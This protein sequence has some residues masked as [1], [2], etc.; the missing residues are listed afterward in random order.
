M[1][2]R[3]CYWMAWFVQG[4]I[5]IAVLRLTLR[6][7]GVEWTASFCMRQRA[8]PRCPHLLYSNIFSVLPAHHGGTAIAGVLTCYT[9]AFVAGYPC[10][11]FC[12]LCGGHCLSFCCDTVR[13]LLAAVPLRW[14]WFCLFSLRLYRVSAFPRTFLPCGSRVIYG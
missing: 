1:V 3:F 9:Y 7:P 10:R 11:H 8:V 13:A 2:L 14:F 12:W 4:F 5:L 6:L